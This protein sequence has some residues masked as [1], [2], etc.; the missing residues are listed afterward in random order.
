MERRAELKNVKSIQGCVN[1]R[2]YFIV[3]FSWSNNNQQQAL[4]KNFTTEVKTA[5]TNRSSWQSTKLIHFLDIL[6]SN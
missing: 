1:I 5:Q 3:A 6:F 4:Q 2:V